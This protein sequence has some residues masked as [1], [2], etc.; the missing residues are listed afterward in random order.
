MLNIKNV[1][2]RSD[3]EE[4]T[5]YYGPIT[6]NNKTEDIAITYKKEDDTLSLYEYINSDTSCENIS[7]IPKSEEKINRYILTRL[8]VVYKYII[9]S[10]DKI[11]HKNKINLPIPN[12]YI[13]VAS[14]SFK[15][16][17]PIIDEYSRM[18]NSSVESAMKVM[19]GGQ[20]NATTLIS[21]IVD[22]GPCISYPKN[23]LINNTVIKTDEKDDAKSI[24]KLFNLTSPCIA[25]KDM[26][27]YNKRYSFNKNGYII[28][29]YN[30]NLVHDFV[31]TVI[32]KNE[33]VFT[34]KPNLM[35]IAFYMI[36]QDPENIT[37]IESEL[38]DLI[39]N[40]LIEI[41]NDNY[42]RIKYSQLVKDYYQYID[43]NKIN[44]ATFCDIVCSAIYDSRE[45]IENLNIKDNKIF[46]HNIVKNILLL[47]MFKH[48]IKDVNSIQDI[49]QSPTF[50]IVK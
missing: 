4:L 8:L 36:F 30:D 11:N 41:N 27:I 20:N 40:N 44:L 48:L 9:E 10:K 24:N 17:L 43:N 6:I 25:L 13:L 33:N 14:Q 5:I 21:S 29:M 2:E 22:D 19:W 28:N 1:I 18:F 3:E 47:N 31:I 26:K 50:K 46:Q 7:I 45:I 23:L 35:L 15:K 32:D 12:K 34:I 38:F 16:I 37:T 39:I 49:S 42:P